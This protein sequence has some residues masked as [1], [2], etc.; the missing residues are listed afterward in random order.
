MLTLNSPDAPLRDLVMGVVP[1]GGASQQVLDA[2]RDVRTFFIE[3]RGWTPAQLMLYRFR[4]LAAL[5]RSGEV[6]TVQLTGPQDWAREQPDMLLH[7]T[8]QSMRERRMTEPGREAYLTQLGVAVT[9]QGR[10]QSKQVAMSD[11]NWTRVEALARKAGYLPERER[12]SADELGTALV[13]LLEVAY[14]RA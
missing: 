13:R 14:G 6:V 7:L 12:V 4:D 11:T 3:E 5:A 8:L 1:P 2:A 9:V 10:M